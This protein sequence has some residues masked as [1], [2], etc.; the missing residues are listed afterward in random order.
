MW[1]LT[2]GEER[3][4]VRVGGNLST[5]D[6]EVALK[7]AI[8]GHGILMRAEWDIARYLRDKR[9]ELVLDLPANFEP[10]SGFEYSNTNYL[11]ITKIMDEALGYGN[12]EYIQNEI[13]KPLDLNNTFASLS[14]VNMEDVM[15]G[16]H[17]E[18]P[19]DLKADEHGMVATANDV[20]TFL[21]A[22]NDGSVFGPGEQEIYSSIVISVS[23]SSY[24][25]SN[26]LYNQLA[27]SVTIKLSCVLL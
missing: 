1:Q 26:W 13:L 3:E 19:F 9:L 18:H 21:R 15:S 10:N 24:N 8:D 11:L 12:F 14:D 27:V 25:S 22:L 5:N 2:K 20:G 17:V 6:G 23:S 4:N 7:W 16:Y